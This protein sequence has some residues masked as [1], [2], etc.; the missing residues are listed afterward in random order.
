[1]GGEGSGVVRVFLR[2]VYF[3]LEERI[4]FFTVPIGKF[5]RELNSL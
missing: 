3:F 5:I 1:M 4:A 2:G